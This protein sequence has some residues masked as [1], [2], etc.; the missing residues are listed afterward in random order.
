MCVYAFYSKLGVTIRLARV[1]DTHTLVQVYQSVPVCCI[2]LFFFLCVFGIVYAFASL[3]SQYISYFVT[4][5]LSL[6]VTTPSMRLPSDRHFGIIC[7]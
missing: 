6:C 1:T 2:L 5:G 3:H 4:K 7:I